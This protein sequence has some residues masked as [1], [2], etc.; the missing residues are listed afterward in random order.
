MI[1]TQLNT[2]EVYITWVDILLMY[3]YY[4]DKLLF[5]LS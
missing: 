4:N 1:Y 5:I 3:G 2:L